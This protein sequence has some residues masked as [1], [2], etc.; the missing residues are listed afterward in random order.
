M[1][2]MDR[3]I[4]EGALVEDILHSAKICRLAL[5]I[6]D[7]PYIVPLCFGYK[8]KRLYFHCAHEGKKID[9][10]KRNNRVC[11]EVEVDQELVASEAACT[12]G[13]KFRSVV[14]FGRA[15][16]IDDAESKKLALDIIMCHYSD[17][18][19]AYN[20][21]VLS[22]TLIIEVEIDSMTGKQKG[23]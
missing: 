2:R 7:M 21:D 5:S 10:L 9:I 1:R 12:W 23:Y 15:F 22:K 18:R 20:E 4:N 6:K 17:K 19:Y 14:G 16:F 8:D 13:M 11:F 3:E